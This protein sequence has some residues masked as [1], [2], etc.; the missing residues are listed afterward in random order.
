[1]PTNSSYF[2]A[3]R[4]DFHPGKDINDFLQWFEQYKNEQKQWGVSSAQI[5]G[6]WFGG[7][8]QLTCLYRVDSIDHWSASVESEAGYIAIS[9]VCEILDPKSLKFEVLKEIP[10]QF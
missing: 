2:L 10:V 9:D 8:R 1:M 6:M 4:G 7:D 3:I 5:F